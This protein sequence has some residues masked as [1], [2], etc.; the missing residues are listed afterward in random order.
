MNI[1]VR[2]APALEHED[3]DGDVSHADA[4]RADAG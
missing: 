1:I 4:T 2:R 3:Q